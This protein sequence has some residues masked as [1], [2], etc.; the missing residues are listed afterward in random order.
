MSS[1]TVTRTEA[2]RVGTSAP[3][4]FATDENGWTDLHF[5]AVLNAPNLARRL[6]A[7]GAPV[8]ARLRVDGRRLGAPL[9]AA[10]APAGRT[11]STRGAGR[12][13]H[14]CTWR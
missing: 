12:A 8:D 13:A 14:R 4:R 3:P 1:G 6:L 9:R 2:L 5:T 7:A 11:A 10:L